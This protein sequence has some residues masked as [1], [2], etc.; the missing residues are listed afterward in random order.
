MHSFN[1]V[2]IIQEDYVLYSYSLF[3]CTSIW[4]SNY[5]LEFDIQIEVHKNKSI[6]HSV[7]NFKRGNMVQLKHDIGRICLTQWHNAE[8][9]WYQLKKKI[10]SALDQHVPKTRITNKK[11]P[12][13]DRCRCHP[14]E[15]T[16]ALCTEEIDKNL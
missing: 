9:K 5:L 8:E 2:V 10:M 14:Y 4:I 3:L 15:Q 6:P 11:S 1:L 16:E 7:F 12:P 13:L